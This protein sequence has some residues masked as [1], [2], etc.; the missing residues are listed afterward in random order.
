MRKF[1]QRI[2]MNI[3][4]LENKFKKSKSKTLYR[5][6]QSAMDSIHDSVPLPLM[7]IESSAKF[8]TP[9]KIPC[10]MH[11]GIQIKYNLLR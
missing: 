2:Y 4:L 1:S 7:K 8:R 11:D 5:T 3:L 6:S 9:A 10:M